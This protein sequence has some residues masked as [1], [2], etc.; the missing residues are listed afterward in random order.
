MSG[1]WTRGK[2]EVLDTLS[3]G[4]R[5]FY[6]RMVP[7]PRKSTARKRLTIACSKAE[8]EHRRGKKKSKRERGRK[9]SLPPGLNLVAGSGEEHKTQGDGRRKE[10]S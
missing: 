2:K 7:G 8:R 1:K 6:L 5:K 4:R 10:M 9:E 3:G